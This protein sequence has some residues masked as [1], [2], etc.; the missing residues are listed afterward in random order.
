MMKMP[1]VWEL[2]RGFK[3][4]CRCRG[5]RTSESEDWVNV[6]DEYHNFVLAKDMHPASF[7]KMAGNRKCVICEGQSYRVAEA[8]CTAWLFYQAPS[9]ALVRTVLENPDLSGKVA[10]YDLSPVL[11]GMGHCVKLNCTQSPVFKEFESYLRDEMKVEFQSLPP[12][13]CP[14]IATGSSGIVQLA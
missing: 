4:S 12:F 5:W 10:L 2:M 9:E 8:A 14:E 6:G 13:S 1:K 11:N 7:K 3:N